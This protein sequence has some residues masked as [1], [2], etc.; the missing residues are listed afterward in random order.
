[1][2]L[3]WRSGNTED[4]RR[5]VFQS[6]DRR[7][8]FSDE[9]PQA[10]RIDVDA[11]SPFVLKI[12]PFDPVHSSP[13]GTDAGEQP[14]EDANLEE[15]EQ[16]FEDDD[17]D[18]PDILLNDSRIYQPVKVTKARNRIPKTLKR[19]RHSIPYPSLP[20]QVTKKIATTCIRA[21]GSKRSSISNETLTAIMKASEQ[22][23]KQVSEDLGAFAQHAGRKKIDESDVI[24]IMKR[25]VK[26]P[27]IFD[28]E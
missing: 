21:L 27:Y 20:S 26:S 14:F 11:L 22:Y 2:I 5:A 1:M 4:L 15:P 12:P 16:F 9:R 7:G 28:I 10:Q 25:Y 6:S 13:F 18:H 19:S 8:S 3:T 24:A 23:F 17:L